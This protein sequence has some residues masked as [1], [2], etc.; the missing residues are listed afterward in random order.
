MHLRYFSY[1]TLVLSTFTITVGA[2]PSKIQ[3][4]RDIRPILADKCFFCHGPDKEHQEADLR[5]DMEADAL[6]VIKAGSPDESELIARILATDDSQMPPKET[7]KELSD[8]EM[9]LLKQWV[10]EG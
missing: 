1:L 10:K 4:D 2:E 9:A 8:V 3:F 7:K 6:A 5:L